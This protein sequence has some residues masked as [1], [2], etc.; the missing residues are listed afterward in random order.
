MVKKISERVENVPS[1]IGLWENPCRTVLRCCD[2]AWSAA[3]NVAGM[4]CFNSNLPIDRIITIVELTKTAA[5][6]SYVFK[7]L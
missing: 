2:S 3:S 7:P 5:L 6:N 1:S 4:Y